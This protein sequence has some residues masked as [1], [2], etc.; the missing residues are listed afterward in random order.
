MTASAYKVWIN[1]S[2]YISVEKD[3]TLACPY[4]EGSL[5]CIL[6]VTS[7]ETGASLALKI[8]RLLADTARENA[9][10]AQLLEDERLAV[11]HQNDKRSQ[12]LLRAQTVDES[13]LAHRRQT[14]ASA[15]LEAREQDGAFVFISF[16]GARRPRVCAVRT[17]ANEGQFRVYPMDCQLDIPG[18]IGPEKALALYRKLQEPRLD[19]PVVLEPRA[20]DTEQ[21]LDLQQLLEAGS[22]N[23]SWFTGVPAYLMNWAAGTLQ[24]SI[25]RGYI[26][27]WTVRQH[28]VLAKRVLMGVESLH[29]SNVLHADIRP[30]N[31]MYE[32]RPEL[33]DDYV[34]SDYG[35]FSRE[36]TAIARG[37]TPNG[38]TQVGP[39]IGGLRVS[40]FYA[41]ERRSGQELESANVAVITQQKSDRRLNYV[42]IMGWRSDL[43]DERGGFRT[44]IANGG[45]KL[46]WIP[47]DGMSSG[48]RLRLRNFI[49]KV[50]RVERNGDMRR[51]VCD[52]SYATVRHD[53]IVVYARGDSQIP[54]GEI[55]S[56]SGFTEYRQWSAATDIYGVG[57]LSLYA[58][59][60]CAWAKHGASSQPGERRRV[61]ELFSEMMEVLDSVPYFVHFRAEI[62]Q[63]VREFVRINR[64]TDTLDKEK[65]AGYVVAGGG[66][67]DEE[68]VTFRE[69]V[70]KTTNKIVASTPWIRVIVLYF[71]RNPVKFILYL[72]FVLSCLH[73]SPHAVPAESTEPFAGTFCS[74]RLDSSGEG[75]AHKALEWIE[76]V[77]GHIN[78]G[79]F[80]G[81]AVEDK[82]IVPFDPQSD[83]ELRLHVRRLH[84]IVKGHSEALR[85]LR[86]CR[87]LDDVK[88]SAKRI[89]Q[90]IEQFEVRGRK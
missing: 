54:D 14:G 75:G 70:L 21:D 42:V 24:E 90:V 86:R 40:P 1:N 60:C 13:P 69:L 66:Q 81:I 71:D 25:D 58:V 59:F 80:A 41:P 4:F 19:S 68:R 67:Q 72:H 78:D 32:A 53:R 76:Y 47:E 34:V 27:D 16:E 56:L 45:G 89:G 12:G 61:D 39:S 28:L 46:T 85:T 38:N 51:I 52:G 50:E 84:E 20:S 29:A 79:L 82:D 10:I 73:R 3:G 88:N 2:Y 44:E 65:V 9:Y 35:S 5:G 18:L 17:A 36:F 87:S 31:V 77:L 23:S 57:S 37:N 8:P 74:S 22:V 11:M 62:A 30:A 15:F 55:V 48:D 6:R 63:I 7:A 26:N 83:L 43:L 49:F 64:S 33:P